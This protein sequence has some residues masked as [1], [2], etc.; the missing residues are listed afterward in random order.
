M[1]SSRPHNHLWLWDRGFSQGLKPLVMN[2]RQSQ[3]S[4]IPH[5]TWYCG[6]EITCKYKLT[7]NP[8]ATG[9]K[10]YLPCVPPHYARCS[11]AH[12]YSNKYDRYI[13]SFCYIY[14]LYF[15]I[16]SCL[17]NAYLDMLLSF[18]G[19]QPFLWHLKEN[20]NSASEVILWCKFKEQIFS[21][22]AEKNVWRH[23]DKTLLLCTRKLIVTTILQ[24]C[25]A[26]H[27]AM[28]R[29]E[30]PELKP[31]LW[32]D[33]SHS[34]AFWIVIVRKQCTWS[35]DFFASFCHQGTGNI[36]TY[37]LHPILRRSP[38]PLGCSPSEIWNTDAS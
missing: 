1:V 5:F 35:F 33:S 38:L 31:E 16:A 4:G 7:Q 2:G 10:F 6:H 30:E 22:V 9:T 32:Y 13:K 14:L 26:L 28:G 37:W 20:G 18:P 12:Y 29:D 36:L 11:T 25:E 24:H 15:N 8:V 23:R 19:C 3:Y 34:Y 27:I 17:V 21:S